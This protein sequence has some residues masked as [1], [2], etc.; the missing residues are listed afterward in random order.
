MGPRTGQVK[1]GAWDSQWECTWEC[2]LGEGLV[3]RRAALHRQQHVQPRVRLP[4]NKVEHA[5]SQAGICVHGGGKGVGG[6]RRGGRRCGGD[7]SGRACSPRSCDPNPQKLAS[8]PGCHN[9]LLRHTQRVSR[10]HFLTGEGA[11]HTGKAIAVLA[12]LLCCG[13]L[14]P[15]PHVTCRQHGGTAPRTI[16]QRARPVTLHLPSPAPT[17][18][19][20]RRLATC[21]PTLPRFSPPD[22]A[23]K[24]SGSEPRG[25]G[26]GG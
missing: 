6:G 12:A 8:S 23:W 11:Q 7:G 21:R 4:V 20:A 18:S 13:V 24:G 10:C 16:R 1:K 26:H 5:C 3:K 9:K 17:H 14:P 25:K 2:E 19:A 15:W 22:A